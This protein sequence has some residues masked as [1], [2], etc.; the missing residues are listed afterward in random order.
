MTDRQSAST[1]DATVGEFRTHDGRCIVAEDRLRIV[2]GERGP[3]GTL[4]EALT[5]DE[6]PP[7][8][9]AGVGLSLVAVVVGAALAIRT[10]PAWLS[11]AAAGLLLAWV[12]WSR[13]RG[14]NPEKEVVIPFDTVESVEPEYGLPLLTRPRFVV[15]HRSEGGVKQRYVLTPSRLYGFGAYERGKELFA[16]RGLVE[17]P[18]AD[19]SEE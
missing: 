14:A 12:V 17:Q 15:R 16:A 10:L 6:I 1:E 11:G 5:D 7:V 13:L 9:R 3:L 4:S 8:R 18:P 2:S 19:G